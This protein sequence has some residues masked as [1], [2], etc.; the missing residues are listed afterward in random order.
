MVKRS[1][2]SIIELITV[3]SIMGIMATFTFVAFRG[4]KEARLVNQ[5]A[6]TVVDVLKQ[7]QTRSLTSTLVADDIQGSAG[8]YVVGFDC[9]V[10]SCT[11]T[12]GPE[13]AKPDQIT[14][15]PDKISLADAGLDYL[16]AFDA[17]RGD[18]RFL[19]KGTGNLSTELDRVVRV[20]YFGMPDKD[21]CV[22]INRI[23][24]RIDVGQCP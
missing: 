3:I 15:L 22:M 9:G 14:T 2:F 12:I 24:G 4:Q 6:A 23:S 1:G 19:D 13:G 16:F 21:R 17:P 5:A 18:M 7:A 10:T 8:A 20:Q 11:I